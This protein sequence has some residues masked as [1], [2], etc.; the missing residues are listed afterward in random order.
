MKPKIALVTIHGMGDTKPDY[1]AALRTAVK[2]ELGP[3]A[4][5]LFS[6]SVYYQAI[7]QTNEVRV[8]N[9]ASNGLNWSALRKFILYGFAD[10]TGLEADKAGRDSVYTKAQVEIARTLYETYTN[11]ESTGKVVVIAQ[12]LGGQVF[13]NYMWDAHRPLAK[14]GMWQNVGA[15]AQ[16]IA[17]KETLSSDEISFLRGDRLERLVTTGCNIPVFVAAHAQEAILP[18]PSPNARFS[19]HNYFDKNDVLGWP[20]AVL[21]EEYRKAVIDHVINARGH[22]LGGTLGSWTPM[23]HTNY[24]ESDSVLQPLVAILRELL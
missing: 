2:K 6:N 18:F 15:H 20:L 7:L 11:L 21:S 10:A 24:W 16:T 13:S 4:Q 9:L 14:V 23:C 5:T 19:W 22:S 3:N 8:W 1:A 17:G 12:S